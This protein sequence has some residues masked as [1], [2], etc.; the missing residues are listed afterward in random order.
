M[1]NHSLYNKEMDIRSL[2]QQPHGDRKDAAPCAS[3]L[4]KHECWHRRHGQAVH[5]MLR[6]PVNTASIKDITL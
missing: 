1:N 2:T 4:E 6:I 5:H 3:V